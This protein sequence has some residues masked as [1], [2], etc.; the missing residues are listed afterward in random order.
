M[1]EIK[2]YVC[3]ENSFAECC[4][5]AQILVDFPII[6]AVLKVRLWGRAPEAL[7][8]SGDNYDTNE[9]NEMSSEI[10]LSEASKTESGAESADAR[11]LM[12]TGNA[13]HCRCMKASKDLFMV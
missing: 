7:I 11:M 6:K 2:A 13:A 1:V 10:P 5:V 4:V 8:R 9:Y 12:S 3:G